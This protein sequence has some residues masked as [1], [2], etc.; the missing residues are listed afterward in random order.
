[1]KVTP[2]KLLRAIVRAS[3]PSEDR[4]AL[5]DELD[6]LYAQ[7]VALRGRQR[8]NWWY[9]RQASGFV[10]HSGVGYWLQEFLNP[11]AF[12]TDVRLAARG[13]IKRPLFAST[14]ILTLAIATGV[15]AVVSAAA[16]WVLLRPVPGV[17]NAGHLS[18]L[19]L[20]ANEGPA[21]IAFSVSHP[22]FVTMAE[23]LPNVA[24]LAASEP[25]DVDLRTGPEAPPQRIVGEMVT[26]NYFSVLGAPFAAGRAF[27]PD[28]DAAGGSRSAVVS[29]RLARQISANP[30]EA[31]G[32]TIRVNGQPVEVVGVADRDFH[33]AELPS[34]V[35][36]WLPLSALP[37]VNPFAPPGTTSDRTNGVWRKMIVRL[38]TEANEAQVASLAKAAN[39]VMAAVR[40]EFP[41]NS[42]MAMMHQYQAFPGVGLNPSVRA[43]VQKTVGLLSLAAAVLLILAI[44]N[45]ANLSLTEASTRESMTVIRYALGASRLHVA[46]ATLAELML[47]GT[48]GGALALVLAWLAGT[49]AGTAQLSEFGASIEGMR[50]EPKVAVFTMAVALLTSALAAMVPL[51]LLNVRI[52]DAM[53]RR[54]S[55]G[56]V[57]GHR[58]RLTFAAVQVALSFALL[59]TAGL[60]GRTVSNLRAI[61]LGFPIDRAITFSLD[62]A[63]HGL[64]RARRGIVA[65]NLEERLGAI[66]GVRISSLVAPTPFGSGYITA[67]LYPM[68][69][70]PDARPTV[71]AGFYASPNFLS[72]LGATVLSGDRQW[73]GD[74]GTVV[75][76]RGALEQVL[77]GVSPQ[78]AVGMLVSTRPRGERPLRIATIIENVRLSD[79]T[80]EPPAVIIQPLSAAAAVFSLSG[81]VR[82]DRPGPAIMGHIRNGVAVAAP[83]FSPFDVRTV[84]SAVDLQFSERRV[85]A[86]A[87]S[88]LGV[89]G[90]LLAAVGLYGVVASAVAARGRE[91][92]IRSALG[93]TPFRLAGEVL[94][95]GFLPTTIGIAAGAWLT[96]AGARMV[97]AYLYEVPEFDRTTY[98]GSIV[99]LLLVVAMACAL[100]AIRAASISPARVLR[101]D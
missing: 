3:L 55:A 69:A 37:V 62:P 22:D 25:I 83:D 1:M 53:L 101:G 40:K 26:S 75:L 51:R 82:V 78:Q 45:L 54:T 86:L 36:L 29:M 5:C 28:D 89:I 49:W 6:E 47:L 94:R 9:L 74:S 39:D 63:G 60:L 65:A 73:R 84:R 11:G 44:A 21:H 96:V 99:V 31:T 58:S 95:L 59:V 20:G 90:L 43:S 79:I 24:G 97:K 80:R 87:A 42:Y 81:F 91:I 72:A 33:G 18:I 64:N 67:A 30:A 8:A 48:L 32:R 57:S 13:A 88:A 98:A 34:R 17:A 85:L 27:L 12:T 77:P 16:N 92:G 15:V 10:R 14:F 56:Q 7:R 66:P 76:S 46:R 61:D 41:G 93:A 38:E 4:R 35:D 19:R 50:L 70:A 23:R 100:P 2:P 71:G 68:D 52:I